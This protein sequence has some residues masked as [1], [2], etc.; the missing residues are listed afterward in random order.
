MAKS[1]TNHKNARKKELSEQRTQ[2]RENNESLEKQ[3][4]ELGYTSIQLKSFSNKVF[5][6]QEVASS[7]QSKA[8]AIIEIHNQLKL[9]KERYRLL[10]PEESVIM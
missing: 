2:W 6:A 3:K 5:I 1:T 9:Q 4:N 10:W 7:D 8:S